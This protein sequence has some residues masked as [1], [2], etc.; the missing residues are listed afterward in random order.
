MPSVPR[1]AERLPAD[2]VQLHSS[3]Y[4]NPEALPAGDV[5]VV[6]TGQSGCQIAEDLHLA[7]PTRA[8][9]RRQ[10]TA[11]RA[12]IPGQGRGRVARRDGLLP[13]A[14]RRASAEGARARQG[15]PL[16]HRPRRRSRHRP[17]QVRHRGHAPLRPAARGEGRRPRVCGRPQAEPRPG[18]RRGREHQAHHRQV[19]RGASAST[20]RRRPRTRRR[21]SPTA[22]AASS[23]S[24]RRASARSYGAPAFAPTTAGSSC[25]PSTERAIPSTSAAS[26]PSRVSTSWG[27]RGSTP[28]ARAASRASPPTRATSRTASRAAS[29]RRRP[30]RRRL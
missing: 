15:Q 25:P 11:H 28:G 27:C 9:V 23:I 12:A 3:D 17:A 4:R 29:A 21:G 19:H 2:V 30:R 20:P 16:R 13:H 7:G 5:M 22:R 10:R 6:G 26:A 1:M 8:P 18:R 24:R 14:R